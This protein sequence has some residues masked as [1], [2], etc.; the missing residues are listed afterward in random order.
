MTNKEKLAYYLELIRIDLIWISMFFDGRF[1]T[2]E[3]WR[4]E[5]E[6][7]LSE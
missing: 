4:E 1:N 5:M 2:E 6:K 3:K 7:R